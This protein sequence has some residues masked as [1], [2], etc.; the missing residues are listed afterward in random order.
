VLGPCFA[1][2]A[3]DHDN[4]TFKSVGRHHAKKEHTFYFYI[5]TPE[6]TQMTGILEYD[7]YLKINTFK[8]PWDVKSPDD[9]CF[10]FNFYLRDSEKLIVRDIINA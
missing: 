1:V 3:I 10:N 9:E 8:H 4:H 2:P 6:R 7:E 5:I